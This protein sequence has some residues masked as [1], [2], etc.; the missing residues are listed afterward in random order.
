M[1]EL[2]KQGDE[3]DGLASM[4]GMRYIDFAHRIMRRTTSRVCWYPVLHRMSTHAFVCNVHVRLYGIRVM[5]L[6]VGFQAPCP[7]Q[8]AGKGLN[9]V[10]GG[11]GSST[12]KAHLK[13]SSTCCSIHPSSS[14]GR[15]APSSAA[16]TAST[17]PLLYAATSMYPLPP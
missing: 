11:A 6:C 8:D 3:M 13:R 1:K 4:C 16:T 14:L 17:T 9:G 7:S 10:N 15:N 5:N 2:E 12:W